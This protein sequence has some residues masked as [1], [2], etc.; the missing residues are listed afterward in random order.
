MT[1]DPLAMTEEHDAF[2]SDI[3]PRLIPLSREYLSALEDGESPSREDFIG[4]YPDLREMVIECLDGIDLAFSFQKGARRSDT[5]PKRILEQQT[6]EPLGDFQIIREIGRGGM[7]V[8]YEAFQ[9]SLARNVALKVLP[10][11]S[12]LDDRHR[13]RFLLEAQA[14]AQLHHS[15]IVPVYAVGCD[16]GTHY[17]AMQLIHGRPISADVFDE[18]CRSPEKQF[19]TAT[20]KYVDNQI[21]S[22]LDVQ[23]DPTVGGSKQSLVSGLRS[24]FHKSHRLDRNRFIADLIA[25]AADAL[26]YA[27]A[28]GVVHRDIKPGNLL[29]DL[30]GKIWITD[31]G[32]AQINA[33]DLLTQTGDL[34]GTLRYMSPEQASGHRG[35][36]DHRSDIYS[37]G[38]TLYE[39]LT[40]RP[41]FDG[42]NRQEL[43]HQILNNEPVAPRKWD[44]SIP[45]ELEIITLKALRQSPGDRYD[46]AQAFG[47][48]LRRFLDETP[49]QARRPTV[50]DKTRKWMRR[51]PSTVL[52]ALFS[53]LAMVASLAVVTAVVTQQKQLTSDSLVRE[54]HR[55]IQAE[56]RL[57]IAQS[58]A[59]EMIRMAENELSISP[60]EEALRQRLLSSAIKYYQS[61]IDETTDDT[62]T[63][64]NLLAIRDRAE[65]I[66]SQ[67]SSVQ[68]ER[69]MQLLADPRVQRDLG[70]TSEEANTRLLTSKQ[71]ERL[72]QIAIQ[73]QGPPGLRDLVVSGQLKLS[74]DQF[75]AIQT[76]IV[77][78]LTTN[79]AAISAE[80]VSPSFLADQLSGV[81]EVVADTPSSKAI[82][83]PEE[84]ISPHLKAALMKLILKNLTPEQMERWHEL[85]GPKFNEE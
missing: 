36:I 5:Q 51:H 26:D 45:E 18:H 32:L 35:V 15:N 64:L 68:N 25:Q 34:L 1:N 58:A 71:R 60:M 24:Q 59:D 70:I 50:I 49:I 80:I 3:D 37:L 20:E 29:L 40:R 85:T 43:L 27:H 62:G 67:L 65:Q 19:E 82:S 42:A 17:Y 16:R 39:M 12:A 47:D 38:A 57:A 77:Q 28:C 55:V 41:V 30:Q 13:K 61:L 4:R 52:S 66:L 33:G 21:H 48:D 53:L 75:L 69:Q 31:F 56:K 73:L 74:P 7:G 14:A 63:Q 78:Y 72:K 6:S 84:L 2:V 44:R 54:Q 11:A 8:V 81:A 22:T 9:M 76:Q 79:H 23:R 46:N 83:S 10:F